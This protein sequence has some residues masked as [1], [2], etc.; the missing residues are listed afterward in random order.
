MSDG[1]AEN[2]NGY[3]IRLRG[4]WLYRMRGV[5]TGDGHTAFRLPDDWPLLLAELARRSV[6]GMTLM[7]SFG[8]PT[9]IGPS[10][11]VYLSVAWDGGSVDWRLNGTTMDGALE[12]PARIDVTGRLAYRNE[13]A[14]DFLDPSGSA[15]EVHIEVMAAG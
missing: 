4:P 12:S 9:G 10:D 7:R 15:P 13:L 1:D 3:V 2:A 14:I 5:D 6:R 8:R 11:R